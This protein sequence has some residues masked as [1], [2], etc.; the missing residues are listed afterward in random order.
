MEISNMKCCV[1]CFKDDEII[2]KIKSLQKI[3]DCD[4]CNSRNKNVYDTESD[5]DLVDDFEGLINT[6]SLES[7]LPDNYPSERLSLLKD[8]LFN[9]WDIFRLDAEKINLLLISICKDRYEE[10]PELFDQRVGIYSF[11]DDTYMEEH[12]L[13]G[14]YSWEDFVT[15]IK[16]ENRFH[17]T[18]FK[19][20]ILDIICSYVKKTYKSGTIFYRA[21]IS[22]KD[23]FSKAEMEAPPQQLATA[24]RVNPEGISYLYL[25]SDKT[26]TINEIRAGLHDYVSIASFK[27]KKEISV[28]DLTRI[29]AISAFSRLDFTQHAINRPH[30]KKIN[31]EIAKPLRRQDSHLDYLP[32]QYICDYIKTIQLN[33]EREYSG[34]EYKSTM[35]KDGFNLAIFDG[36]LFECENITVYDVQEL[37]YYV[38][39]KFEL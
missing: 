12:S 17:T 25:G 8:E 31:S 39:P 30:L 14:G 15:L 7:V 11:C 16:T 27:L 1:E 32:T 23:G 35:N 3:G 18:N 38:E 2:A 36:S 5:A 20:K 13:L 24:G 9:N 10:E 34:I 22:G 37:K 4:L 28:V 21:R 33:G 6:Y 19:T 29:D 26:T